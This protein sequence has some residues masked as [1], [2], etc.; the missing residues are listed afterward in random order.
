MTEAIRSF[1]GDPD[2][3]SGAKM[4]RKRLL[5]YVEVHIEQGPVLEGKNFSVGV[6]SAIA[7]QS[8]IEYRFFGRAGHAGTVPMD[9]R[10]DA[11]CAAAE[12]VLE[13]ETHAKNCPGLV[14][15]VGTVEVLPGASNV[16][17]GEV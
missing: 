15:T 1:G 14:A 11:L 8:R 2:A 6:V 10:A 9:L 4:D 16:I 7:G 5:G 13:A 17:P 12:F 3:L